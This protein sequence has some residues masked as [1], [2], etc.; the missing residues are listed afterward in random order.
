MQRKRY[1]YRILLITE[2]ILVHFQVLR[3]S[4]FLGIGEE[5][6]DETVEDKDLKEGLDVGIELPADDP[7][8]IK[9]T[10]NY[11]PNQ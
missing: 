6:L 2:D 8:V 7:E 4:K 5:F 3:Y 9:G 11:G 10:P 1:L